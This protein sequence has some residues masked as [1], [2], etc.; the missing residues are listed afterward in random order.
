MNP[1]FT[2]FALATTL[3]FSAHAQQPG[4][5]TVKANE[6]C[7]GLA[8]QY[9]GD[10]RLVDVIHRAN[11]TL[12]TPPPHVLREGMTIVIPP[13]PPP[14]TGPD[15]QLTTVKNQV[16]ILSPET[17]PGR[18]NDPLFKGNRVSTQA[19]SSADVT[20]RDETQV[21][22]GERTLVVILG[23][24][25]AAALPVTET[26]LVTGNLRTFM[27]GA[28]TS[29]GVATDAAN[30]RVHSG[31]AKVSTDATK[32]TRVAVY[33]G[34][35]TIEARGTVREV[36]RGFGAKAVIGKA[37]EAPEPLPVA[38]T[39]TTPP[40]SLLVTRTEETPSIVASYG[41]VTPSRTVA[42]WHVQ[43]ARDPSF[44]DVVVDTTVPYATRRIE[45]RAPG[46]GAWFM[47]VSAIDDQHFEGP[48]SR[49]VQTFVMRATH[50]T[51]AGGKR[52]R[53]EIEPSQ[54]HCVRVGN[55]PLTPLSG[56]I[57][58]MAREPIRIRCASAD[59]EPTTLLAFD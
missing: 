12:Q 57:E 26:R 44:R 47:R 22:L 2:V 21:R 46:L 29:T 11:P 13:K 33:A 23:D 36:T 20:F 27:A 49:H 54:V 28:G 42:E 53:L 25:K 40:E 31:E 4:T 3:A 35:S 30:V 55:V 17:K 51:V 24:S 7:A 10:P 5:H 48:Y 41:I 19:A 52:R 32:T 59:D 37:P 1:R 58:V 43:I 38:P 45:A 9:Y 56:P 34:S 6:T 39:W 8:Q 15:A 50:T 14:L 18:A 16:E